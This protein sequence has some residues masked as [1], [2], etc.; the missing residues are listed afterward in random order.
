MDTVNNDLVEDL[1]TDTA[2]LLALLGSLSSERA[3]WR[4]A[5]LSLS[6]GLPRGT[7]QRLLALLEEWGGVERYSGGCYRLG[8][9]FV[10]LGE[11]AQRFQSRL[12]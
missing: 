7:T 6:A 5:D 4:V 8:W 2:Q 12:D 3:E 1:E 9:R 11:L 10:G